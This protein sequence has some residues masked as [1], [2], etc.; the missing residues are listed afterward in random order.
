MTGRAAVAQY[1]QGLWSQFHPY[2][3]PVGFRDLP[4]GRI[5]VRV[6]HSLR[7][8]AGE[9]VSEESYDHV[10]DLRSGQIARLDISSVRPG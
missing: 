7:T 8:P 4:D 5:V 2:D 6:E 3:E 9:T 1:W 10:F